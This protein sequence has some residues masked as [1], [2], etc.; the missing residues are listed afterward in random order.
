MH[1]C[2]QACTR[3]CTRVPGHRCGGGPHAALAMV[4]LRRRLSHLDTSFC[5]RTRIFS[6][7]SS[8]GPDSCT[9]F[10]SHLRT[11]LPRCRAM[12]SS[13]GKM[14]TM[15]STMGA[16]MNSAITIC[17]LG[18]LTFSLSFSMDTGT[19][20]SFSLSPW[21]ANS[22]KMR[23]A[24]FWHS[25]QGFMGLPMSAE[26][27]SAFAII[28]PCSLST[29]APCSLSSEPSKSCECIWKSRA[30]SLIISLCFVTSVWRIAW[31]MPLLI[32]LYSPF[33]TSANTFASGSLSSS[34]SFEQCMFSRGDLSL[35]ITAMSCPISTRKELL[36]PTWPRSWPM[37]A[38]ASQNCSASVKKLPASMSWKLRAKECSTSSA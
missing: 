16:I 36:K 19:P 18:L 5:T 1:Q 25:S 6:A 32:A 10:C 7:A 29:S 38:T 23:C 15:A 22:S 11:F 13:C 14:C 33:S 27:S 4:P 28:W 3:V 37:A 31:M 30:S 34:K 8:G 26:C 21:R 9:H 12:G 2:A 17:E 35:Y 24:S 20:S